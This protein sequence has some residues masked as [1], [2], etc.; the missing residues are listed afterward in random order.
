MIVRYLKSW[1]KRNDQKSLNESLNEISIKRILEE[2]SKREVDPESIKI[3][4]DAFNKIASEDKTE[5][6]NKKNEK[7]FSGNV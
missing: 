6:T 5:L 2:E 1:L 7:G 3:F 4:C